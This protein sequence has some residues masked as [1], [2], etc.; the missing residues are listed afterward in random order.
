LIKGRNRGTPLLDSDDSAAIT[1]KIARDRGIQL[2]HFV[3]RVYQNASPK[4]ARWIDL[5]L[6]DYE[7]APYIDISKVQHLALTM[8]L[9]LAYALALYETLDKNL[10]LSEGIPNFPDLSSG[11]LSLLGISHASYLA[12]KV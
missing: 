12:G 5:V 10:P 9:L 11:M 3:G 2:G 7:G 1:A 6:G 4:D 8:L